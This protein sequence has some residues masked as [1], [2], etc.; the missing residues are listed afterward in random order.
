MFQGSF[1]LNKQ[2]TGLN[3]YQPSD[4]N[5]YSMFLREFWSILRSFVYT[6]FAIFS[7]K[8]SISDMNSLK[9]NIRVGVDTSVQLEVDPKW[10]V[11]KVKEILAP[12]VKCSPLEIRIIFAGRELDNSTIL[13][14]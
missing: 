8:G 12:K 11:G 14:A 9:I 4:N 7:R 1:S 6:V 3:N 5:N 10:T 13:E 2:P